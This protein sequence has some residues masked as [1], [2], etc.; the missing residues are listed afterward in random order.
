MVERYR[1]CTLF[2][3]KKRNDIRCTK[4]PTCTTV[5]TGRFRLTTPSTFPH[6]DD[7]IKLKHFPRYWPFVC[8]GRSPVDSPHKVQWRG[9]LMFS[10][11]CASTSGWTNSGVVEDWNAMVSICRYYN[12]AK[13]LVII[14]RFQSIRSRT[15]VS[16]ALENR[17]CSHRCSA[18]GIEASGSNLRLRLS[19]G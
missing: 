4:F 6:H 8:K 1:E 10:L 12:D 3:E 9:A 15:C 19:F 14:A 16:V 18:F 5:N 17:D 11:I 7:V 13:W 2:T